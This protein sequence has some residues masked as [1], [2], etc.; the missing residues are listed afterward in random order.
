MQKTR[1]WMHARKGRESRQRGGQTQ[2]IEN[3]ESTG[4]SRSNCL[5]SSMAADQDDS[6]LSN[7]SM[8]QDYKAGGIDRK[9]GQPSDILKKV[10]LIRSGLLFGSMDPRQSAVGRTLSRH[11]SRR[12]Y[13]LDYQ[14]HLNKEPLF[15]SFSSVG[16]GS[17]LPIRN[18]TSNRTGGSN[19]WQGWRSPE[20]DR[21][22]SYWTQRHVL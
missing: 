19:I 7:F 9:E 5:R 10:A 15:R 20:M 3:G 13:F 17:Q 6:F 14:A 16:W 22:S 1:P 12:D 2:T 18:W 4:G 8:R 11:N 21:A